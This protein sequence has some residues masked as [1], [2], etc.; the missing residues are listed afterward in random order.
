MINVLLLFI[1]FFKDTAILLATIP[2]ATTLVAGSLG[3]IPS[4][5]TWGSINASNWM[6][7]YALEIAIVSLALFFLSCFSVLSV[8]PSLAADVPRYDAHLGF[9]E[10]SLDYR[11]IFWFKKPAMLLLWV[12]QPSHY[13]L[14]LAKR[15]SL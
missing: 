9:S 8:L 4:R 7:A 1:P 13:F 2:A 15:K 10:L 11:L 5:P 3:A 12:F 6:K 14:L